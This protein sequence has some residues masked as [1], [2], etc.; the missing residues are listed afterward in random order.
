[1]LT[2]IEMTKS[3]ARLVLTAFQ[4]RAR[5]MMTLHENIIQL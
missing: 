4:K 2:K 1:M 5:G 3:T